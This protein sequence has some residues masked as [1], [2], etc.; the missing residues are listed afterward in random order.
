M[1][2]AYN[3]QGRRKGLGL[4]SCAALGNIY[5]GNPILVVVEAWF[6]SELPKDAI[7]SL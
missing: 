7:W 4:R 3:L 6:I 2:F 1:W 5:K